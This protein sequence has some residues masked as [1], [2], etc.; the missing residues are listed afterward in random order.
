MARLVGIRGAAASDPDPDPVAR[1]AEARAGLT[2][3]RPLR[4]A[5]DEGRR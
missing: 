3:G 2:L 4:E 1:F 5:T